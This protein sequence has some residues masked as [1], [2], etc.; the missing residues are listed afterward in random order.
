MVGSA[1]PS[2]G[3]CAR[4]LVRARR[5]TQ[6]IFG[7]YQYQL[8]R[9]CDGDAM[10]V[11]GGDASLVQLWRRT[12][13]PAPAAPAPVV[14]PP[15][16]QWAQCAR[17]DKWRVLPENIGFRPCPTGSVATSAFRAPRCE[18]QK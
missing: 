2:R 1:G 11:N 8:V 9:L 15:P 4:R 13:V 14:P 18:N 16:A 12:A 10:A 7:G 17:C 5:R 6:S 3:L